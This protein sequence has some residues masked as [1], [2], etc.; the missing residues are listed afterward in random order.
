MPCTTVLVGKLA[1]NDGSTI[2]ARTDDG[3]FE[4]KQV[5]VIE[6]KNQPR[7][8]KSV[9]AHLEIELEDNPLR[10]TSIPSVDHSHGLWPACGINSKNVAMTATETIS[11][12]PRVLGADPYVKYVKA[13]T[14][15]GKDT[16]GG[17]GE[18]DLVTLVL[19]YINSAKE[20]VLRVGKLLEEYG[21]YEANGMAFSDENEVW[22]LETIGGHHWIARRIPDDK[23]VIMPNQFGMDYFDFN[24]KEN[25]LCSSDLLDFIEE[26]HLNVNQTDHFN[27]RHVFG[28]RRDQDH[29]Y[30]TP[31]AW[32]IA[33]YFAPRAYVWDGESAYFTPESD[34]IPWAI[35]PNEKVTIEDIKYLLSSHYQG[36][37][38][39][40]YAKCTHPGKYRSIGVPNSDDT[41]ILQIRG[42]MPDAL[43]GVEW[44]SLGGGA[45]TTLFAVYS[46][47][48]K[49]PSYIS[50][51]SKEVNT[52]YMYWASRLLASLVDAHYT[53]S[54]VFDE[55]YVASVMN[56]TREI[57]NKYDKLYLETSDEKLLSKANEEILKIVQEETDDCLAKV[58]LNASNHMKNRFNRNDN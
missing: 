27:P 3:G 10:Y 38:Y 46:N 39:D 44:L 41:G 28:S 9:I 8:Y 55:R 2:I 24:D 33:R 30:N 6:P 1:S 19:P 45:F 5:L 40:P 56:R 11:S 31:R 50:E 13:K 22:W 20:G 53:T 17:I 26:N 42:Y 34:D 25:Y 51:T 47:V 58:L 49:M 52:N 21:T 12:N 37:E 35:K 4:A 43:K 14:K 23:V 32:F 7:K 54:I 48:N 36:T 29:I 16:I 57:L 15:R 18:E